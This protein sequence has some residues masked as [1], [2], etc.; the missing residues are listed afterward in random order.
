M[1]LNPPVYQPKLQNVKSNKFRYKNSISF[2]DKTIK[3]AANSIKT[4]YIHSESTARNKIIFKI[5]PLIKFFSFIYL[6]VS[7]SLCHYISLQIIFSIIICILYLISDISLRHV[8]KKILFLT[9]VFGFL[10][11]MPALFNI[12]TPGQII[13]PLFHLKKEL[14]WFVYKIPQTIGITKEGVEIVSLLCLRVFNSIFLAMLYVY[15]SSFSQ[16]VKGMKVFFVPNTFLMVFFLAYKFIF[17]LSKTIEDLYL[18]LKSRLIG[19]IKN[20]NIRYMVSGRLLYVFKKAKNQYEQT[21][22]AMISRGYTGNI[23]FNKTKQIKIYDLF[24]LIMSIIL[25]F[26]ILLIQWFYEKNS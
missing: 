15:G 12:I 1:S 19:N 10:I 17:I 11:F 26:S 20:K 21:H 16:I 6:I 24:C 5:N 13:L 9:G 22:A 7:I 25:G 3:A 18:A 2:L 14:F 8:Y 4:I 23:K